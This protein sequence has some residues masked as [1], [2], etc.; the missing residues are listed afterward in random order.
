MNS[1]PKLSIWFLCPRLKV[2]VY[3][4]LLLLLSLLITYT[5][6]LSIRSI[7]SFQ[8]NIISIVAKTIPLLLIPAV[9]ANDDEIVEPSSNLKI[10]RGLRPLMTDEFEISISTDNVGLKLQQETYKGF[11]VVT[12]N[13]ILDEKIKGDHPELRVGAIV[14]KVGEVSTSGITLNEISKAFKMQSRPLIVQFRDPSRFFETLDS[15]SNSSPPLRVITTSYLPGNTRDEGAPE[16]IIRVERI[17]MPP[18]EQRT[19]SAQYLD[20]MEIQYIAQIDGT[21]KIVDSS[22]IWSPPGY[23]SKVN[24]MFH[25]FGFYIKV[26]FL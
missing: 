4:W 19:R 8:K 22:A 23:S 18:V 12:V 1:T 11:P 7:A 20:V 10:K 5:S 24:F 9:Q 2:G 13:A 15:A 26:F 6:A 25:G 3:M 17:Q 16:Q 21:D 14:T